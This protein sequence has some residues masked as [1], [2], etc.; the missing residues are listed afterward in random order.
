MAEGKLRPSTVVNPGFEKRGVLVTQVHLPSPQTSVLTAL[1]LSAAENHQEHDVLST[2]HEGHNRRVLPLLIFSCLL[3][4]SCFF[5]LIDSYLPTSLFL[6]F[7]CF[8][9]FIFL[10]A[11]TS[12]DKALGESPDTLAAVSAQA[13]SDLSSQG[14]LYL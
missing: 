10:T 2:L 3:A 1:L 5:F 4:A 13:I 11:G 6:F 7:F 12:A 8:P 14:S 9:V